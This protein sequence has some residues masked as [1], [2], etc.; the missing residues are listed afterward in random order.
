[1]DA[2]V[3]GESDQQ[4]TMPNTHDAESSTNTP[5]YS[6]L[7]ESIDDSDTNEETD[8]RRNVPWSG[9]ADRST[10]TAYPKDHRDTDQEKA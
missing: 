9:S 5:Y 7:R 3:S 6:F 10:G 2:T 4:V 1:M 8:S